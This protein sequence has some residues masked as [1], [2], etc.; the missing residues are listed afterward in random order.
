LQSEYSTLLDSLSEFPSI[1]AV[2]FFPVTDDRYMLYPELKDASDEKRKIYNE[3]LA[4]T[5]NAA[6]SVLAA[7]ERYR[8]HVKTVL[9]V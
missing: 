8:E 9:F 3:A 7:Y 6:D 1:V 5:R 2:N 4:E